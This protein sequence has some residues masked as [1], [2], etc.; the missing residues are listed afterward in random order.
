MIKYI[1]KKPSTRGLFK[2]YG[3]ESVKTKWFW[4]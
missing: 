4:I 1:Q 2:L 3:L